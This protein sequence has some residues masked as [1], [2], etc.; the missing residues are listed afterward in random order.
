MGRT[1]LRSVSPTLAV[2]PPSL[3]KAWWQVQITDEYG[4]RFHST[5]FEELLSFDRRPPI[6]F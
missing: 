5:R 6:R 1:S 2:E 3:V 4:K